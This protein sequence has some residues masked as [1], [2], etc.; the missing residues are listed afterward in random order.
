MGL[1]G[2][3][4][5]GGGLGLYAVGSAGETHQTDGTKLQ[6]G[7]QHPVPVCLVPLRE[8]RTQRGTADGK[9]P[10]G[11]DLLRCAPGALRPVRG[12]EGESQGW[13]G[14]LRLVSEGT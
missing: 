1:G 8:G 12:D 3:V 13:D 7:A 4:R 10:E 6:T 9:R 14:I 2:T 11:P 5:E